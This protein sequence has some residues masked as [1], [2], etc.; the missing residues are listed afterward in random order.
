MDFLYMTLSD[1]PR[2]VTDNLDTSLDWRTGT[3]HNMHLFFLFRILKVGTFD[4][5][6]L[7]DSPQPHFEPPP[8]PPSPSRKAAQCMHTVPLVLHLLLRPSDSPTGIP[9]PRNPSRSPHQTVP[10]ACT[11]TASHIIPIPWF[12]PLRCPRSHCARV[13]YLLPGKMPSFNSVYPQRPRHVAASQ[14]AREDETVPG[15]LQLHA[16]RIGPNI[17]RA[18][19][20]S[21]PE[22]GEW[23]RRWRNG[24]MDEE[25]WHSDALSEPCRRE[26]CPQLVFARLGVGAGFETCRIVG[27]RRGGHEDAELWVRVRVQVRGGGNG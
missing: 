13:G 12:A 3:I 22:T 27:G 14:P 26:A 4:M 21:D 16:S 17:A 10:P 11:P 5:A 2:N 9:Q 15:T 18:W 8:L 24:A 25:H 20:D 6:F 23:I 1:L 7:D 19:A